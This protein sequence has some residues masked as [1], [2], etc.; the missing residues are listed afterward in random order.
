MSK[1]ADEWRI[2]RGKDRAKLSAANKAFGGQ[3]A[4]LAAMYG[5]SPMKTVH[6][7]TDTEI[8]LI[9]NALR[10]AAA[11]YDLDVVSSEGEPRIS[12]AFRKQSIDAIA[13]ADLLESAHSVQ[14][15]P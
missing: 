4:R 2:K 1:S 6:T 8:Y 11:Q 13:M 3:S 12:N 9:T 14:V 7:L 15:T 10:L 5:A